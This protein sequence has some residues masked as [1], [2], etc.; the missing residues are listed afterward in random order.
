MFLSFVLSVVAGVVV[1]VIL[2]FVRKW[3]DRILS[4]D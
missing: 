1:G 3:L 4:D 2:Y